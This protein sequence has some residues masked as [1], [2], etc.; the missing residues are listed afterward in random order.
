MFEKTEVFVRGNLE[1]A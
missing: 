1:T